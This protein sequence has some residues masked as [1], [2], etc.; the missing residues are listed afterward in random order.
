MSDFFILKDIYIKTNDMKSIKKSELLGMLSEQKIT[1]SDEKINEYINESK[2]VYDFVVKLYKQFPINI[3]NLTL[4]EIGENLK[5]KR[6]L[7]KQTEEK[8]DKVR[9]KSNIY[10]NV[11][12]NNEENTSELYNMFS[13]IDGICDEFENTLF[14]FGCVCDETEELFRSLN[15]IK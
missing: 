11:C 8:V 5:Q 4:I 10:F 13:R 9:Q 7:I 12:E 3:L 14:Y 15:R 1:Y 2:T 6:E